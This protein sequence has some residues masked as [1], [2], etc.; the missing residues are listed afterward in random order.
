M[1]KTIPP[2]EKER[3]KCIN[4]MMEQLY[5]YLPDIYEALIDKE[6]EKLKKQTNEMIK[7]LK[8]VQETSEDET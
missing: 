6:P 5:A 8:Y 3:L 7:L 4:H 2:Q 1:S